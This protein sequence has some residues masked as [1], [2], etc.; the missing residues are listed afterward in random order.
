MLVSQV[1]S[2]LPFL[3]VYLVAGVLA[4]ARWDRHPTVSAL[5]VTS[6]VIAVVARAAIIALPMAMRGSGLQTTTIMS[7]AYGITSLVSTVALGC[8][9]AAVFA[10][11][12]TKT[13]PAP[14]FR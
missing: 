14:Q 3:G 9:V 10:D 8:L 13:G 6:A 12:S 4:V 5:V 2:N 11:R 7:I 1:L